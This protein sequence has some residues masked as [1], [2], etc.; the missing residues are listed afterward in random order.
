MNAPHPNPLINGK[1]EN[2]NDD[3]GRNLQLQRLPEIL[4]NNLVRNQVHLD[5]GLFVFLKEYGDPVDSRGPA[6][7][8]YDSV[9]PRRSR[10]NH[11]FI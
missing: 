11:Q 7:L 5:P 1:F 6:E 4:N 9:C 10:H 2:E 3:Q 8:Q